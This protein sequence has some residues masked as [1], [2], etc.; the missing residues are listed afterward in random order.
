MKQ[1]AVL[2]GAVWLS[3]CLSAASAGALNDS[4]VLSGKTGYPTTGGGA[5]V[6]GMDSTYQTPRVSG[7]EQGGWAQPSYATAGNLSCT[8]TS[9]WG[10]DY[11]GAGAVCLFPDQRCEG[12]NVPATWMQRHQRTQMVTNGCCKKDWYNYEY[13]CGCEIT[14]FSCNI[15]FCLP[16]ISCW[17]C[18]GTTWRPQ[19]SDCNQTKEFVANCRGTISR[20]WSRI[21]YQS[22]NYSQSTSCSGRDAS[23]NYTRYDA[24]T[25]YDEVNRDSM[26]PPPSV[27][28]T[29]NDTGG[30]GS[31]M[32]SCLGNDNWTEF[33]GPETNSCTLGNYNWDTGTL[34]SKDGPNEC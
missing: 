30:G 26:Q 1:L 23:G 8:G 10:M 14:G 2:A 3:G 5:S 18:T 21:L 27:A 29:Y 17:T 9:R 25:C 6:F 19:Y 33:P 15:L 34:V 28:A 16:I 31:A 32:F 13:T 24:A 7:Q 4:S 11:G 12:N 20:K 22:R